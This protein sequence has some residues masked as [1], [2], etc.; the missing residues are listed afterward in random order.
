MRSTLGVTLKHPLPPLRSGRVLGLVAF[1][2]IL[3]ACEKS[4]HDQLL[5][6]RSRLASASYDAAVAAAE[7]G[8]AASPSKTDAWGLELV[9]LEAY[10]RGG[11]GDRAVQQL[12]KLAG[13]YP[14]QVSPTD[15]S[16]TAQQLK[17]ADQGSAAIE[18]LDLGMKRHPDDPLIDQMI[19]ESVNAKNS[20]DELE[21]LKSLGYID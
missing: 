6:A 20:P 2:T 15:Y 5:D 13:L 3:Y 12:M 11:K 18:V 1:L 14:D 17:V 21:M 16:S 10:A 9:V 4:S 8:L 19:A 7:A